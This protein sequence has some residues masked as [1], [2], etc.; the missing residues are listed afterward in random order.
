MEKNEDSLSQEEH[1]S[2]KRNFRR[3]PANVRVKFRVLAIDDAP[4]NSVAS[5]LKSGKTKN[6]SSA[7]LFIVTDEDIEMGGIWDISFSEADSWE[8]IVLGRAVW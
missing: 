1:D 2:E 3:F 5:R 4:K 8:I 7:G 6:M